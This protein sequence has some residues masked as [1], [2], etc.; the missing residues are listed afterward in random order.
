MREELIARKEEV[1]AEIARLQ[2]Q[3][4]AA[5]EAGRQ[6]RRTA[7]TERRLDSLMAEESRLRQEID[8]SR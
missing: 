2:R 4:A 7:E 8:R 3:L 6:P 1:R 5:R